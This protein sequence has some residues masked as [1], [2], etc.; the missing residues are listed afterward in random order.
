MIIDT[1][2]LTVGLILGAAVVGGLACLAFIFHE[3]GH[4]KY[5]RGIQ[6]EI[7]SVQQVAELSPEEN[8]NVG[9]YQGS[10]AKN[11]YCPKCDRTY[12]SLD[13]SP[14]PIRYCPVHQIPLFPVAEPPTETKEQLT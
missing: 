5:L 3:W 14:S 8:Q 7:A 12:E 1:L 11:W 13:T 6:Q 2:S 9:K 10:L 4:M